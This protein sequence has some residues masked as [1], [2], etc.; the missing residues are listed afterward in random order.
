VFKRLQALT[1]PVDLLEY[2]ELLRKA[3]LNINER[4]KHEGL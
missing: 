1:Y 4:L 3:V 2:L